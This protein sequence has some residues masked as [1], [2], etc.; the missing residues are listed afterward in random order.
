MITEENIEISV[1][2]KNK[3]NIFNSIIA[4]ENPIVLQLE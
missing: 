4:E 1:N 3:S 2:K